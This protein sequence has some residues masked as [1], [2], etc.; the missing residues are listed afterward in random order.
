MLIRALHNS[1]S[2]LKILNLLVSYQDEFEMN[3]RLIGATKLSEITPAMVD[4]RNISQHV[5]LPGDSMFSQHCEFL[6][7]FIQ[8][9]EWEF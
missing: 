6:A 9:P 2:G 3:M 4:A 5:T 1:F 8:H 7:L